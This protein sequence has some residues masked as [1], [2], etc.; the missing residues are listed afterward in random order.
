MAARGRFTALKEVVDFP[1][2]DGC[3][4]LGQAGKSGKKLQKNCIFSGK[5]VLRSAFRPS[6]RGG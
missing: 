3:F 1:F 5:K 2:R 6:S 4:R